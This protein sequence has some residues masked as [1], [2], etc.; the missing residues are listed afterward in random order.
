MRFEKFSFFL[1]SIFLIG[2][3][4]NA[5]IS[6]YKNDEME[7]TLEGQI[8]HST[9]AS[10]NASLLNSKAIG[11]RGNKVDR[12]FVNKTKVS[13]TTAISHKKGVDA[14]ATLYV[15]LSWRSSYWGSFS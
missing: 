5:K 6:L 2:F 12:V 11:A 15:P 10:V 1:M 4:L 14:L 3:N 9:D 13:L 7:A 8:G